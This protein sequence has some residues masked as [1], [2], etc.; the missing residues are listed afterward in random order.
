MQDYP[1]WVIPHP[2]HI[3]ET[4]SGFGMQKIT[5]EFPEF[6]INRV[7]GVLTVLVQDKK[8]EDFALAEKK[9]DVEVK[10][11][12]EAEKEKPVLVVVNDDHPS[13]HKED[14]HDHHDDEH[15]TLN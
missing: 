3:K 15:K 4:D 1:K 13:E 8:H 2:S 6:H 10:K 12:L 9:A 5:P 7:D 11:E 14:E